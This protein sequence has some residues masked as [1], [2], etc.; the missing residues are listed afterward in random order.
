VVALLQVGNFARRGERVDVLV[1]GSH[2][3][4]LLS[5]RA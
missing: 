2:G 4:T 3:F 1:V 5:T